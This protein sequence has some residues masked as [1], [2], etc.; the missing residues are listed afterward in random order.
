LDGKFGHQQFPQK[1][2]Q[3]TSW[4]SQKIIPINFPKSKLKNTPFP[5]KAQKRIENLR[6]K[7]QN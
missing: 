7:Q 1:A 4:N 2:Q 3:I 6:I 5:P